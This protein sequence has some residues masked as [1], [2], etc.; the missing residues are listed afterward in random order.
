M[1]A[2][3][4]RSRT[5]RWPQLARPSACRMRSRWAAVAERPFDAAAV[6]EQ[7]HAVAPAQEGIGQG[8]G[9]SH[10]V[11]EQRLPARLDVAAH[12]RV[13]NQ[14]DV[15]NALLLELVREQV[16]RM[17]GCGA[18]VD[19]TQRIA[20]LVLA[21]AEE[22]ETGAAEPGGHGPAL[23]RVRRGRMETCG[24]RRSSGRTVKLPGAATRIWRRNR[25]RWSPAVAATR[26]N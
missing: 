12:P 17:A 6:D 21:H 7:R 1:S 14:A 24:I 18:P 4:R 5:H 13:E 11:L 23:A 19:P 20:G 26:S 22:G 15:R 3:T 8:R 2:A 16:A 9:G 10:C 25:P